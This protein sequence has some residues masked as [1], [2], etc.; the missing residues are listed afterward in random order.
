MSTS[1]PIRRILCPTDF[2]PFSVLSLRHAARLGRWFDATIT[3]LHVIPPREPVGAEPR[4]PIGAASD[5]GWRARAG[6]ELGGVVEPIRHEAVVVETALREGDPWRQIVDAA[7]TLPADL[8]VMGTHGR[9]GFE[10]LMLGSVAEK[11]LRRAP[12]PMLTVCRAAWPDLRRTLYRRILCASDLS[13]DAAHTVD[14]A[15][16]LAEENEAQVILLHVLEGLPEGSPMLLE[17]PQGSRLRQ[18]VEAVALEGL[19]ETVPGEAR[20]WCEVAERVVVGKPYREILRVA[21]EER[22]DLIVL[23]AHARGA[24]GR[25]VF[26]STSS[27][28]VREATCPVLTVRTTAE[29]RLRQ[30]GKEAPSASASR[31]A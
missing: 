23:G 29:Q 2:S 16:S 14:L 3:A 19:R 13:K 17:D 10:H 6:Q 5:L 1:F 27:H 15:L 9:S 12:C 21:A 25:M 18:E 26:G 20:D 28:V 7:E 24:L 31:Q 11:V 4:L 22:A 8:I 30:E